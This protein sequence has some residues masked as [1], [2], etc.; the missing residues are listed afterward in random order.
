MAFIRKIP[1]EEA[2][3][4]TKEVY[5]DDIKAPGY[6]AIGVSP[7]A[8]AKWNKSGKKQSRLKQE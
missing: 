8:L 7:A 5:D 1:P 6:I 3:G 4:S 2:T